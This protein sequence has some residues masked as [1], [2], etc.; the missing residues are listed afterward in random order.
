MGEPR[1]P[2]PT[3]KILDFKS[4]FCPMTPIFFKIICLEYLSICFFVNF[5]K[6]F[7]LPV[8]PKPPLPLVVFGSFVTSL[9]LAFDTGHNI[10]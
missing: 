3:I 7:Y 4:F 5:I 1:P 2:A 9:S 8:E 6:I 10:I